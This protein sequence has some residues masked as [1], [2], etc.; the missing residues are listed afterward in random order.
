MMCDETTDGD[1]LLNL[2]LQSSLSEKRI[3]RIRI[4][5]SY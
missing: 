5:V 2:Y 4:Q 3:V 1:N